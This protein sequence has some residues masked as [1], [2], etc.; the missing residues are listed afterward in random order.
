K[1]LR[2]WETRTGAKIDSPRPQCVRV[3]SFLLPYYCTYQRCSSGKVRQGCAT[4]NR[5][6]TAPFPE[7]T[8]L[9]SIVR[10]LETQWN[11]LHT[12]ADETQTKSP[13]RPAL[14]AWRSVDG[15][16]VRF[17]RGAGTSGCGQIG[18]ATAHSRPAAGTIGE[19]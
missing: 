10:S 3:S 11:S 2:K 19:S 7:A 1:L 9:R 4:C 17:N 15:S 13:F 8:M 6:V 12:S 16:V 5:N 18:L 14:A